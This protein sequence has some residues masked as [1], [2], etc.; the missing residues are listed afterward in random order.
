VLGTVLISALVCSI[1]TARA[2]ALPARF[3]Q[4]LSD[5]PLPLGE[6]HFTER[7][8]RTVTQEE[9]RDRIWIA[10]FIF[11]RCPLSCPRISGVMKGL[12]ERL[13]KSNALLVSISVDPEHDTTTVL[14]EYAR[15]FGALADRWWFLTG[16]KSTT[17]D[18]VQNR[19]KLG[20]AAATASSPQEGTELIVHSDRLALV[21]GD[22]VIGFFD[23]SDARALDELVSRARRLAQSGWVRSLPA[24]N[25]SLNALCA[26]FLIAGWLLVRYRPANLAT[27]SSIPAARTTASRTTL[28][29]QPAVKGHVVFMIL[30]V[31]TSTL[32]L[33][34]YLAY[35]YQA[36]STPFR[37]VGAA[38]TMYFTI[39]VSHTLL[40]SFGVVPLVVVTLLRAVRHDFDRHARIAQTTFPIWL[41]VSITGVII[42]LMLYHWS[43]ARTGTLGVV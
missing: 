24:L 36:G 6:F 34:S 38:R 42:Y 17:Y 27:Q 13:A 28:L 15:R 9:L 37:H 33:G 20:L 16:P 41:Y 19:F 26:L 3:G 22:R 25:A 32:F 11:T 35:H 8:G 23:S 39:L 30:A 43:P 12:Q 5:A 31:A 4:D 14:T 18:L 40:A 1:G 29:D 10:S 21:Q 7:T 2:P